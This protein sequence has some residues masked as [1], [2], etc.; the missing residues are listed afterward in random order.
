MFLKNLMTENCV[1]F[2]K[3]ITEKEEALHVLIHGLK[4]EGYVSSESEFYEAVCFRESLSPTG[5]G[6]GI[7]I[8]HGKSSCVNKAGI[9]F[10]K[11]INT[12]EWESL[13]DKGV[14]YIFL[15]AIPEGDE[16]NT[17]IKMISELA[18]CLIKEDII[19]KIKQAD[20]ASGLLS[21][22]EKER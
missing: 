10:M 7:A 22:F 5:L 13:D 8:P 17:H 2:Q 6:D 1:F 15:L 18:R 14:Q 20:N 19:E 21:V 11:L 3:N 16:Q 9:A 4:Q 12:I